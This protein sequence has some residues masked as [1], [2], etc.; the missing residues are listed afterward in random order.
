MNK[1]ISIDIDEISSIYYQKIFSFCLRRVNDTDIA[2][3]ITQNVFISLVSNYRNVDKNCILKWLYNAARNQIAEYYRTKSRENKFRVD[4]DSIE[5]PLSASYDFTEEF[6]DKDIIKYKNQVL[7]ELSEQ[8]GELYNDVFIK[9]L[10]YP[11]LSR[12]Y[13]VSENALRTRVFRLRRKIEIIVKSILYICINIFI[14]IYA[15]L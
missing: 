8:E 3:D 13:S 15:N 4:I 5:D 7:S 6:S 1:D 12:K 2:Y 11:D 9:K 10:S 14:L